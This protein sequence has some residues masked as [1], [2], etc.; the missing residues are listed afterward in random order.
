MC[1]DIIKLVIFL[2]ALKP[3]ET[4][5][6]TTTRLDYSEQEHLQRQGQT[7]LNLLSY[8]VK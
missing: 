6:T 8:Q 7:T 1:K 2:S 4:M 5:A 3:F